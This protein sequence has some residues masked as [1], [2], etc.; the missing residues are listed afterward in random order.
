MYLH[1]TFSEKINYKMNLLH[2]VIKYNYNDN[3]NYISKLWNE[4]FIKINFK[5]SKMSIISTVCP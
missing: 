1:I 5:L 4:I 2:F 3:N